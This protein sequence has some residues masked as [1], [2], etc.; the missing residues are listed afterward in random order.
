MV[1]K[2]FDIIRKK[3]KKEGIWNQHLFHF[4]EENSS[5]TQEI[6]KAG[7]EVKKK[8]SKGSSGISKDFTEF[9][10]NNND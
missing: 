4:Y 3:E 1:G 9:P 5:V 7:F 10:L 2:N 8:K 6:L